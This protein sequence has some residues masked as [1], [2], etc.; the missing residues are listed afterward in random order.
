KTADYN[1]NWQIVS[2]EHFLSINPQLFC[3]F[4]LTPWCDINIVPQFFYQHTEDENSVQF[5]DLMVGLDFQLLPI[6]FT[7]YFPGIKFAIR[8][9]FP[10]AAMISF[11]G[12][13]NG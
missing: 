4:G 8:E 7:T 2:R 5:G 1:E 13:K 9:V 11:C 12:Q 6:D 3:Y 10:T